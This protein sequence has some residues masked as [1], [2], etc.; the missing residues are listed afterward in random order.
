MALFRRC[1]RMQ[2]SSIQNARIHAGITVNKVDFRHVAS[3][4]FNAG[5]ALAIR[6]YSIRFGIIR[7]QVEWYCFVDAG[8][9]KIQ[10]F[11]MQEFMPGSR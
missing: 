7:N 11:K 4:I 8:G 2:D 5:P 1:R 9:C 3:C 10:A 6:Y